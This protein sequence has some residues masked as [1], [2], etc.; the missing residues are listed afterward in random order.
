M[1]HWRVVLLVLCGP[2][3]LLPSRAAADRLSGSRFELSEVAHRIEVTLHRGHAHLRVRRTVANPGGKSDQALLSLELPEGAVATALRTKGKDRWFEGELMEAEA[4]AEKYRELT[5]IG[6]AYPKD[7]ALLSWR[8]QRNLLLQVFPVP[9]HGQLTFEY[10]L[11][12]PTPYEEGRYRLELSGL[13]LAGRPAVVTA[14]AAET[15]DRVQLEGQPLQTDDRFLLTEGHTDAPVE[16]SLEPRDVPRLDSELAVASTRHGRWV[17]HLRSTAAPRLSRVPR[18]AYLVVILDHSRS[19]SEETVRAQAAAARAWLSHFPDARVKVL[20]FDREVRDPTARAPSFVGVPAAARLLDEL[21]P[22]RRNGSHLDAALKRADELLAAAPARA[23]RRVLVLTDLLTREAVTPQSTHPLLPRSEA[24]VHVGLVE[25][26]GSGVRRIDDH[27]WSEVVGETGGLVWDARASADPAD[28]LDLRDTWEELARPVAFDFFEVHAPGLPAV[29][30]GGSL[31][32]E[33]DGRLEEGEGFT[34][35]EITDRAVPYLSVSGLLWTEP[36]VRMV[37]PTEPAGDLWSALFFG[38]ELLDELGEEEMMVL[39]MRGGAVS[40][41]TSYLAIEPGVRPS[42]E[43][44]DWHGGMGLGGFGARG[45]GIGG[46]GCA[47]GGVFFDH[48]AWLRER[49]EPA[50][51]GCGGERPVTLSLESTLDEVVEVAPR[52]VASG[53]EEGKALACLIEAAWELELS[54]DF[55]SRGARWSVSLQSAPPPA[56]APR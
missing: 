50:W 14:R 51:R 17:T 27:A 10:E 5:G 32:G 39:A 36:V 54:S 30:E 52:G 37:R 28:E 2:L 12:L 23:E 20:T 45:M 48:V 49:L 19:L 44:L 3:L 31:T 38:S 18:G 7:P 22:L 47:M 42:T 29:E 55:R 11:E 16:L 13:T 43:G 4:A 40:P 56:P 21:E 8:D 26:Q 24:L 34:H 46:A 33:L 25:P 1:R 9:A 53:E 41:V 6:G 35:L 15:G